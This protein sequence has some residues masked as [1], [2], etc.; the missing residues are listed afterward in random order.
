MWSTNM[1]FAAALLPLFVKGWHMFQLMGTVS[2]FRQVWI[3]NRQATLRVLPMIFIQ[4][5]ILPVFA[6]V[7]QPKWKEVLDLNADA[8]PTQCISCEHKS[9]TI[10][11]TE[12]G[13]GSGLIKST[14]Q[15]ERLEQREPHICIHGHAPS[16][17]T[18]TAN[19][20]LLCCATSCE[21]RLKELV[22]CGPD[23]SSSKNNN[24]N[25]HENHVMSVIPFVLRPT[26]CSIIHP[27]LKRIHWCCALCVPRRK[28]GA[29]WFL[30]KQAHWPRTRK[31]ICHIGP[32][33]LALHQRKLLF[34]SSN[35]NC[36]CCV[37]IRSIECNNTSNSQINLCQLC[38]LC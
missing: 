20:S 3:A 18:N 14:H 33:V 1:C 35:R 5:V 9:R 2:G 22:G 16:K 10:C 26:A 38:L 25:M 37:K 6:F 34:Q 17:L 19:A 21:P 8:T 32:H 4:A 24:N 15:K 23:A 13:F 30:S 11:F 31:T 12:T 7:D 36:S 29:N 27:G 28:K